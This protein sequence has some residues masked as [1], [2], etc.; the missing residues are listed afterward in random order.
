MSHK[1]LAVL[2]LL[3]VGLVACTPDGKTPSITSF[4]ASASSLPIGGGKVNLAW[5]VTDATGVDIDGGVGTGLAVTGSKNDVAVT[6][7]KTFTLTASNGSKTAIKTVT[8]TVATAGANTPVVQ[9]SVP[10]NNAAGVD[11]Q[12]FVLQVVFD[13]AMD[14]AATQ[15]AFQSTDLLT[16]AGSFAWSADKKTLSVTPTNPLEYADV[17]VNTGPA[18]V[19][20]YGFTA[21][22]KDGAGNALAAVTRTFKTKRNLVAKTIEIDDGISG[23]LV[24]WTDT[25]ATHPVKGDQ[26]YHA[27]E[28]QVGDTK[29]I[30]LTGKEL[31]PGNQYKGF[32][33]F[34]LSSLP[35]GTTISSAKL[36]LVQT[37]VFNK[38]YLNLNTLQVQHIEIGVA[39]GVNFD[40]NTA[41]FNGY[42][43]AAL[44]SVGTITGADALVP[45][46]YEFN[47]LNEVN[48]DLTTASRAKRAIFRLEFSTKTNDTS[49]D[50]CSEAVINED[51]AKFYEPD[52]AK[53]TTEGQYSQKPKL[54]LGAIIP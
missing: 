19:Y 16:T 24:Y 36:I 30:S 53:A 11:K 32:A 13:R 14:T 52:P 40:D 27:T 44:S 2:A 25:C 45:K 9:S 23:T 35:S 26:N 49:V 38:P 29:H 4:T 17:T 31:T 33:G 6:A 42:S 12:G 21:A 18:K 10:D 46:T 41:K 28:I 39:A 1:H 54:V 43:N 37:H 7:S 47:V 22:A 8:V 3:F 51:A 5:E 15:G 48:Q 20:T 34:N 50:P